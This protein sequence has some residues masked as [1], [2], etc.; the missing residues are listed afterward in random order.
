MAVE[1]C[2][3]ILGAEDVMPMPVQEY[4]CKVCKQ[5]FPTSAKVIA[6]AVNDHPAY[7]NDVDHIFEEVKSKNP[8]IMSR[9]LM[10]QDG[11]PSM[12]PR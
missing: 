6:H 7:S 3:F 9:M 12:V 4:R 8:N 1:L 5:I 10:D 2:N 11:L